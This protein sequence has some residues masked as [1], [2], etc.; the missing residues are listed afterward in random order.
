LKI[1]VERPI[2]E[3]CGVCGQLSDI[4]G[5]RFAWCDRCAPA[6]KKCISDYYLR[7]G[8]EMIQESKNVQQ[9]NRP[10]QDSH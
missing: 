3:A 4:P 7:K 10:A 8:N 9:G 1:K 5:V 2:P 6:M